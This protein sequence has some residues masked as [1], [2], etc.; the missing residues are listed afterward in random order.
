M[1]ATCS[2]A[3]SAKILRRTVAKPYAALVGTPSRFVS[4]GIADCNDAHHVGDG[5]DALVVAGARQQNPG[6]E[7]A[8]LTADRRS[9]EGRGGGNQ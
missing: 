5:V 1:T 2:G 3:S 8:A 6:R 7:R 4:R 9:P